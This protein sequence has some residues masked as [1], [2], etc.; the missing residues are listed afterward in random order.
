M[1]A[2]QPDAAAQVRQALQTQLAGRQ[3]SDAQRRNAQLLRAMQAA[4]PDYRRWNRS[5]LLTP[6]PEETDHAH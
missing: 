3:R 4:H 2:E 1:S 6:P 5:R